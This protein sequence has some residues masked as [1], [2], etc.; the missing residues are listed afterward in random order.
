MCVRNKMGKKRT[1]SSL[2]VDGHFSDS[3]KLTDE[4]LGEGA[5]A[6]VRT[7]INYLNNEEYAVKVIE[8]STTGYSR[9]RVLREVEMFHHCKGHKNIVR[10]I[11]FFEECDRF[12]LVFEKVNGGSLLS[13]IQSRVS[14]TEK[15]VVFIIR[16]LA[17]ALQFLHG[18]GIAHRDLK[19]ENVLCDNKTFKICDFDLGSGIKFKNA[20]RITTPELHTPVG[21]AEFMAPEVVKLFM[22]SSS[23]SSYDKKCDLWS[24]GVI[25]YILLCNH[26]PFNGNC[27]NDCGWSNGESCQG[28][29]D[30]LFESIREGTYYFPEEPIISDE[31]CDLINH[32]LVES[33]SRY[34]AEDILCHPWIAQTPDH[35]NLV[36]EKNP[37]EPFRL[38]SPSKSKLMQRRKTYG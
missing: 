23:T 29:Q 3:Y 19:P 33:S 18:K 26:S 30:L 14:F 6:T 20:L 1:S 2:L 5:I 10:F 32:L 37:K 21:S 36:H 16:D 15:E 24:I 9:S 7:C 31:A 12:F 28:C 4:T 17:V 22:G 27:G 38:L 13:H 8:K 34:S 11:E 35:N 25:M